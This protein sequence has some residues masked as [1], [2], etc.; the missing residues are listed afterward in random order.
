MRNRDDTVRHIIHS[1]TDS[2]GDLGGEL[3]LGR[4]SAMDDD[5]GG[6]NFEGE[7]STDWENWMPAPSDADPS[8]IWTGKKPVI[9]LLRRMLSFVN[10]PNVFS[11]ETLF[12]C[13]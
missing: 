11:R 12:L 7:P 8:K 5:S 2:S 3:E 1:L 13:W 4:V 10:L 6:V 9:S